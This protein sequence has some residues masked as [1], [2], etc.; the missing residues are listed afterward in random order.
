[1]TQQNLSNQIARAESGETR[2]VVE[3]LIEQHKIFLTQSLPQI[4]HFSREL[5]MNALLQFTMNLTDELGSHFRS[6]EKI[7]FPLVIA[8]EKSQNT[9]IQSSLDMI[10]K[11]MEQDHRVHM[12]QLSVLKAFRD[13]LQRSEGESDSKMHLADH[14]KIFSLALTMHSQWENKLYHI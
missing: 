11:H 10:Y 3:V 5:E 7:I 6:E 12:K 4:K 13:E 14:L 2:E 1:M 9:G 8:L